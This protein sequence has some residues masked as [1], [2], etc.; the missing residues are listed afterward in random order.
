MSDQ[1]ED[2]EE[3]FSHNEV[4]LIDQELHADSKEPD[5]VERNMLTSQFN[6][7]PIKPHFYIV[8]LGFTRVYIIFLICCQKVYLRQ[9]ERLQFHLTCQIAKSEGYHANRTTNY[10]FCTTSQTVGEVG[11]VKTGLSPHPSP[12][13]LL[14]TAP[15][16]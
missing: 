11:P 4:H 12:S 15:R 8:K 16:R 10:I 6:L 13:N 7:D 1:V 2:P 3:R 14:L 9:Q 5:Q